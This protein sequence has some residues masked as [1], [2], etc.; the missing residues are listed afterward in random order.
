[1]KRVDFSKIDASVEVDN[2]K[3]EQSTTFTT[4]D[5]ID[6]QNFY[7]HNNIEQT[8]HIGFVYARRA[9]KRG[10]RSWRSTRIGW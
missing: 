9:G 10:W 7:T 4:S 3:I 1:M 2:S 5:K 8:E 6:I